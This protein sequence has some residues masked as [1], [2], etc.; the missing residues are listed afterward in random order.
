MYCCHNKMK[1]ASKGKFP[2]GSPRYEYRCSVCRKIIV[3]TVKS[4]ERKRGG[5]VQRGAGQKVLKEY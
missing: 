3:T 4:E 1:L 5:D 2:D